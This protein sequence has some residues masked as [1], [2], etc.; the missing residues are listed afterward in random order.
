MG[1]S[2]GTRVIKFS[3]NKLSNAGIYSTIH[4]HACMVTSPLA[5]AVISVMETISACIIYIAWIGL[6]RAFSDNVHF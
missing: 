2:V 1:T 3:Q 6:C 5:M 4:E